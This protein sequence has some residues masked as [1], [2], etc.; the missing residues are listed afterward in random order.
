MRVREDLYARINLWTFL[1]PGLAERPED[2][3]PN[4]EFELERQAGELGRRL[5]F[6][7]Q[8]RKRYLD[9]ATSA[10]AA[11]R[12]SFRELSASVARMATLAEGG[13]ITERDVDDEVVRLRDQ[14]H[15]GDEADDG[16]TRVLPPEVLAEMDR[17]DRMQLAAVVEVCAKAASLS[18]AGRKLF[19]VSRGRKRSSNDAD[20]L[21]KYLAR[22]GLSWDALSRGSTTT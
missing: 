3:E 5:R 20:R 13:R 7:K 1:L 15:E 16:L 8:A 12:G 14:W 17:F 2:I 18:A 19:D 11:W 21:R 22:F 9:Y 4:L 6:N 10:D